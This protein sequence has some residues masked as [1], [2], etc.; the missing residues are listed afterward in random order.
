[1]TH[2]A[3]FISPSTHTG[4]CLVHRDAITNRLLTFPPSQLAWYEL[5]V[6]EES[7]IH[8]RDST[9][10]HSN[11]VGH[12]KAQGFLR[13]LRGDLIGTVS[14]KDSMPYVQYIMFILHAS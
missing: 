13:A 2:I 12:L 6:Q 5:R 14:W 9:Q 4:K 10:P 3:Y 1:M 11:M 8:L 7:D